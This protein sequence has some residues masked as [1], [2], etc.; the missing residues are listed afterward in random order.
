MELNGADVTDGFV[1]AAN[2]A[3]GQ[4]VRVVDGENV[5]RVGVFARSWLPGDR[6]V[7]HVT[8]VRFRVVRP[9]RRDWA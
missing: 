7:E 1:T 9:I 6:L 3:W 4:V 8:E 2:G 5:L